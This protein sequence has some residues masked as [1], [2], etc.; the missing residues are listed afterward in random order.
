MGKSAFAIVSYPEMHFSFAEIFIY[1]AFL[2]ATE[3]MAERLNFV[4]RTYRK[5]HVENS[6]TK[7]TAV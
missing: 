3:T 7:I 6:P 4:R 1:L 2:S 5:Q